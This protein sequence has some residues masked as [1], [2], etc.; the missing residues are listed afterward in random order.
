MQVARDIV[1]SRLSSSGGGGSSRRSPSSHSTRAPSRKGKGTKGKNKPDVLIVSD[2]SG[3]ADG[4]VGL[5]RRGWPLKSS[6]WRFLELLP[7]VKRAPFSPLTPAA[8]AKAVLAA[9]CQLPV[10]QTDTHVLALMIE[11]AL[12]KG[13]RGVMLA[14]GYYSSATFAEFRCAKV[15]LNMK[16]AHL[17]HVARGVMGVHEEA[18][19][20]AVAEHR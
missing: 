19:A 14:C 11:G 5:S 7:P 18:F 16:E 4:V 8:L 20:A 6:S 2:S 13:L 10:D 17:G 12:D 1:R 9:A 15:P 3:S